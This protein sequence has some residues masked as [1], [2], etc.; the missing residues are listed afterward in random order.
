VFGKPL[1]IT[2]NGGVGD[3]GADIVALLGTPI[4]AGL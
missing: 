4:K 1:V 3:A 2:P